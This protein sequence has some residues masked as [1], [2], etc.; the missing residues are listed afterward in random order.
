MSGGSSQDGVLERLAA[1]DAGV[2]IDGSRVQAAS[3]SRVTLGVFSRDW[4]MFRP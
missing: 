3:S 2:V 1:L 4:G